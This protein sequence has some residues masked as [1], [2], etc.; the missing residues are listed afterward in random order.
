MHSFLFRSFIFLQERDHLNVHLKA[1]IDLLL[2]QTS[3][4]STSGHILGRDLMSVQR[5]DAAGRSLVL[6]I[7]K[8]ISEFIRV[9]Y[10]Y[11][12]TVKPVLRGHL[13]E[14]EKSVLIRQVTS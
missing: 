12:Y 14:K 3:G 8:I 5:K 13:R 7:T 10:I 4:K 1:V 2:H 9:I 11:I 6:Q